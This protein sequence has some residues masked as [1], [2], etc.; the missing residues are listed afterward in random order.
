MVAGKGEVIKEYREE[1]DEDGGP[2]REEGGGGEG[3][4]GVQD[5]NVN[6]RAGLGG[7]WS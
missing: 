7:V 2:G 1:V 6:G 3:L 4:G 5:W